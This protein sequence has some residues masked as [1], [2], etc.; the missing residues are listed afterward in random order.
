[1]F[2]QEGEVSTEA[3]HLL[4]LLKDKKQIS[5]EEL[6]KQLEVP[7]ETVEA[8]A[9]F[10]E[11]EGFVSIVYKF[12]TPYILYSP[13]KSKELPLL[14]IDASGKA[15]PSGP[16]E[17][18]EPIKESEIKARVLPSS[19]EIDLNEES[20]SPVRAELSGAKPREIE[21]LEKPTLEKDSTAILEQINKLVAEE[22]FE[23]AKQ[24]Y[25]ELKK[26]YVELPEEYRKRKALMEQSIAQV[27]TQ[28]SVTFDT[29]VL[30]QLKEYGVK[31]LLLVKQGREALKKNDVEKAGNIYKQVTELFHKLPESQ[32]SEKRE[33]EREVMDFS[34][35]YVTKQQAK[36]MQDFNLKASA[37]QSLLSEID[38]ALATNKVQEA[39]V[40]YTQ[41]KQKFQELPRGFLKEKAA[42]QA[43]ILKAY[44]VLAEKWA[45]LS[46]GRFNMIVTHINDLLAQMRQQVI[47]N[48]IL[49]AE[50]SYTQI[51]ELFASLP[52][53]FMAQKA[54]LQNQIYQVY[55]VFVEKYPKVVTAEFSKL[56]F[57][58]R[59]LLNE[60]KIYLKSNNY[61]LAA[62]L[63]REIM[64]KF[65]RLPRVHTEKRLE[66]RA[67]ITDIYR[68]IILHSDSEY[69]RSFSKDAVESY[70]ELLAL[71]IKL[72][73]RI[74]NKEFDLIEGTFG[75]IEDL[76]SK[77]PIAIINKQ[78]SLRDEIAKLQQELHLYN[79][80]KQLMTPNLDNAKVVSLAT[81]MNQIKE[82]LTRAS[83]Q[84]K[85]LFDYVE[86]IM[87]KNSPLLKP[88]E[89]PK[90]SEESEKAYVTIPPP[91]K[92]IETS[93]KYYVHIERSPREQSMISQTLLGEM[94]PQYT[95]RP[96]VDAY[97]SN[98]PLESL[99]MTTNDLRMDRIPVK[100]PR[101]PITV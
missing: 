1:M 62:E 41:I 90:P 15:Y 63:Y 2:A 13:E 98:L 27:D 67:E 59:K 56:E 46:L 24:L 50:E 71:I 101:V 8:W 57:Q 72:H 26:N 3:D 38:N 34:N 73:N 18:P 6:A 14:H 64:H 97:P 16:K 61:A 43:E 37:L 25:D 88:I 53:G 68:E 87:V 11:E 92:P 86:Q 79:L 7:V 85:A 48:N 76:Y 69:L 55:A 77:L 10:L 96:K 89:P 17:Q 70:K 91:P 33:L 35:E 74:N 49:D 19:G 29:Y 5:F 39:V 20:F 32:L 80:A 93:E 78:T 21:P 95:L 22:K 66:L 23:D 94:P 40:Y 47:E 31:I 54:A 75:I 4:R 81:E 51:K 83:P 30:K 60:T 82:Y 58:I 99:R 100:K 52:E 12:T 84:D 45:Q 65:N 28:L 9:T 42:L 44:A 36:S